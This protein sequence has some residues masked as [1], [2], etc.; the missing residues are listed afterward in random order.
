M[1]VE[2]EE[3]MSSVDSVC[4]LFFYL[5]Y[6][7]Y[8]RL[9]HIYHFCCKKKK[10]RENKLFVDVRTIIFLQSWSLYSC[11]KHVEVTLAKN[12]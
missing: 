5:L 7:Q 6:V 2:L 11:S 12:V 8:L 1:P 4:Q 9:R 3:Q 10:K